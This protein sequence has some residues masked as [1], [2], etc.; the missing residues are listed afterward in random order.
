M[1]PLTAR[2]QA[3]FH[4]RGFLVVPGVFSAGDL[5]PLQHELTA[6][7]DSVAGDAA[8]DAPFDERLGRLWLDDPD[9]FG[10]EAMGAVQKAVGSAS[11]SVA[12]A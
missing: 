2:Q 10:S 8:R 12:G 5:E 6:V 1:P 4:S 3:E 11:G 7:I 9:G